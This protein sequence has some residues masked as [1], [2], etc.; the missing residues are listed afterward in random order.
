MSAT[1][2]RLLDAAPY[3]EHDKLGPLGSRPSALHDGGE[4]RA[5]LMAEF[6]SAV[7]AARAAAAGA[8]AAGSASA[9]HS[10]RKALRRARAV[11]AMIGDAL[12]KG[13]RGTIRRALQE[14]RRALST[15][16]DHAVA[17]EALG[18]LSLA[19][20]DRAT[21]RQVLDRAAE[22]IPPLAEIKQLLAEAAAR[23]AA[24]AE[25]LE[26]ALPGRLGWSD[27]ARGIREI[28][29]EARRAR[30]GSKH[31][32]DDFHTWR[33][34]TKELSYALDFVARQAGPRA[35]AIQG[36]LDAIADLQG[37]AVDLI[38]VR[39]FVET[40]GVGL[41]A[42]AVAHLR[43]AIEAQLVDALKATRKGASDAFALGPKKFEKRLTKAV[44]RDLTPPDDARVD[45][46]AG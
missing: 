14:A 19:D 46:E 30:R 18:R 23:A 35:A 12:P 32:R 36:E 21:A 15:I 31:A 13:E 8:D 28:Y 24:Q 27:V 39:E 43:D 9:V 1:G 44:K 16:R 20:A 42:G 2:S 26:A 3:A 7:T 5:K 33:R 17:P 37:P 41:D 45:G 34:R 11:L 22:A 6:T 40:H 4:L 38:M 25:A 29:D 10:A